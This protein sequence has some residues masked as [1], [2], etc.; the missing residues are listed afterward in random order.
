[1]EVDGAR[2]LEHAV[3]LADALLHP[4]HVD[5]DAPFPAVL[6]R[7]DLGLVPP[8]DLVVT[9]REERRVK[10]D[11][12]NALGG[13]LCQSMQVVVA[14]EDGRLQVADRCHP[15]NYRPWV[16]RNDG[17]GASTRY[18]PIFQ[19]VS[20]RTSKPELSGKD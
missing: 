12:V 2:R 16:C 10:V 11:Q 18:S 15:A 17:L 4:V 1:M 3:H 20:M 19:K 14:I 8:D 13:E 7:P 5:L 6:E 9:V